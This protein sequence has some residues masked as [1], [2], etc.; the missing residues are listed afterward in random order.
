MTEADL[1]QGIA[2]A[3]PAI[4]IFIF[5]LIRWRNNHRNIH[6]YT[7]TKEA[8]LTEAASLHSIIDPMVCM[9]CGAWPMS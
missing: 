3:L 5:M 2:Y 4:M 9:G 7:E 1:Y 6:K 8:G